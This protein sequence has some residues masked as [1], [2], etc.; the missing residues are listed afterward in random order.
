M[1]YKAI[2]VAEKSNDDKRSDALAIIASELAKIGEIEKAKELFDRAIEIAERI[3][4]ERYRSD[5]LLYIIYE[6]VRSSLHTK[7]LVKNL[8]EIL[9]EKVENVHDLTLEELWHEAEQVLVILIVG[10]IVGGIGAGI[11]SASS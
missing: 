10:I 5:A 11:R 7:I 6:L 2:R 9:K 1:L 3:D 4:D 8:N